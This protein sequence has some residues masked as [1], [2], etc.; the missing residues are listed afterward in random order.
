MMKYNDHRILYP[1]NRIASEKLK[2][3]TVFGGGCGLTSSHYCRHFHIK[4]TGNP[5]KTITIPG[6]VVIGRYTTSTAT[7]VAAAS[8][9]YTSNR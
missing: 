1:S 4:Y 3:L 5:N 9:Q 6:Q 7:I 8:W 2:F